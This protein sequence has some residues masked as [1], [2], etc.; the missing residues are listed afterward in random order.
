MLTDILG[1]MFSNCRPPSHQSILCIL[2]FSPFLKK[3]IILAMCLL[4]LVSLPLLE[5][6]TTYLLS[7]ITR[8]A[9]YGTISGSLF[10]NSWIYILK[11]SKDIPAVHASL[12]SF[13]ALDWSTGTGTC[14]TWSI[15]PP[16]SNIL[17]SPILSPEM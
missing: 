12:Y 11:C 15:G 8:R 14:V 3:Y 10:N 13:S 6:H 1:R 17:Y 5:I 4:W 16:W 7:N 9:S 2:N